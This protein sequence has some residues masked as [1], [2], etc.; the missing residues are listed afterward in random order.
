MAA[1]GGAG[2]LPVPPR[3]HAASL[4]RALG[5]AFP[6]PRF[7]FSDWNGTAPIPCRRGAVTP[8]GKRPCLSRGQGA[9]RLEGSEGTAWSHHAR[10]WLAKGRAEHKGRPPRSA[11]APLRCW[12]SVS[13]A[14]QTFPWA[15]EA[16][17]S[18]EPST[19]R[20]HH[21]CQSS[22]EGSE[23]PEIKRSTIPQMQSNFTQPWMKKTE[24]SLLGCGCQHE[25]RCFQPETSHRLPPSTDVS[26]K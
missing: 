6:P 20:Q 4:H 8:Q 7:S 22:L 25:L 16:R 5:R 9:Q 18:T 19:A 26:S 17:P 15:P 10:C 24:F 13:T 23:T 2:T 3:L 11:N 12:L 14:R 21:E 1:G